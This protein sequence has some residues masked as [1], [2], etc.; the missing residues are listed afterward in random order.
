[1]TNRA[2]GSI[3]ARLL[4]PPLVFPV[5]PYLAP[6]L[7]KACLERAG[8]TADLDDVNLAFF[9]RVVAGA[10][11]RQTGAALAE[12]VDQFH[13]RDA[14][15]AAEH[16]R[17]LVALLGLADARYA[18]V[19]VEDAKSTLRDPARFFMKAGY[20]RAMETIERAL[21]AISALYFPS[22]L[23][24][25]GFRS[26]FSPF[27]A[28]EILA[29]LDAADENV[30]DAFYRSH[31]LDTIDWA[32]YDLVGL[33]VAF[34]DQVLPAFTL[35]RRI[36]E[37]APCAFICLGGNFFSRVKGGIGESAALFDVVD[38]IVA[39]EGESIIVLLAEALAAGRDIVRVP[40]LFFRRGGA[41]TSNPPPRPLKARDLP[42]PSFDG[43]RLA[44]YL[45]PEP[46]FPLLTFKGCTYGECT[47]CDHHV[48]YARLSGRPAAAVAQDIASLQQRHGA[49]LFNFV[50]EEMPPRH[51]VGVAREILARVPSPVRWMGY[52]IYRP[53]W[54][55][56]DW[57]VIQASG[58]REMLFGFE[59]AA[60][61]I[62]AR[63]KKPLAIGDVV[64]I[65]RDLNAV[66]VA[67]RVN[68][69][70]G[71]PGETDAEA[72]Q[73][74]DFFLAAAD[75][76]DVPGTLVAFHP[77]LLVRN[78]PLMAAESGRAIADVPPD[79]LLALHYAYSVERL[80]DADDGPAEGIAIRCED[81]FRLAKAFSR[82]V[83]AAYC[84][85]GDPVGRLH[86]FPYI[87]H[88][89]LGELRR[90][91]PVRD[92]G[93]RTRELAPLHTEVLITRFDPAANGAEIAA[94][95]SD[96]ESYEFWMNFKSRGDRMM[97]LLGAAQP[98]HAG[99]MTP[100]VWHVGADDQGQ[101]VTLFQPIAIDVAAA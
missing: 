98:V 62:L 71:F 31:Y 85:G 49:R 87:C 15:S 34:A 40:G 42:T 70:V 54:T 69:I 22:E 38:G 8:H 5:S 37:R 75:L 82:A 26:R 21:T 6:A 29:F 91:A 32:A 68:I 13:A 73:S 67:S 72:A 36:K 65:T 46:M 77:F 39:S 11:L 84:G 86:R 20:N 53:E 50:D 89:D 80:P 43:L 88:R 48:N 4:F 51:A 10:S 78:A 93:V 81:A 35:A 63:M 60:P 2:E 47:F 90:S 12:R 16:Y 64:R 83:D 92:P 52:A 94:A 7:L 30:F 1:M 96:C 33:S 24:T 58:C 45:A 59:S 57:G 101:L 79:Q 74:R 23:S 76:F 97:R 28:A 14:L 44:S 17:H 61:R 19:H 3:R 95:R 27:S 41:V 55:A 25:E 66:G 100:Y 56:A 99:A 9:D 18:T